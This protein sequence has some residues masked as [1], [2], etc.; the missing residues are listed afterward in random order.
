MFA[1]IRVIVRALKWLV[2]GGVASAGAFGT[3]AVVALLAGVLL[4]GQD[5]AVWAFDGFLGVVSYALSALELPDMPSIQDQVDKLAGGGS[6]NIDPMGKISLNIGQTLIYV[7]K[8]SGLTDALSI[9]AAALG[10][11]L[12]MKLIPLVRL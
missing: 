10:V 11:K 7:W 4:V 6:Q 1:L 12:V 3:S 5:L 9:I 8:Q 2:T